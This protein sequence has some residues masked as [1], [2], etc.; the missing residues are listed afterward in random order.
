MSL[1]Q[2]M[3]V[4]AAAVVALWPG[5]KGAVEAGLTAARRV[6]S[7]STPPVGDGGPSFQLAIANLALVRHRLSET[8]LLDDQSKKAID[9]L[10]L[11]LV[12]GSD[13]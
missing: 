8:E 2:M 11:A 9:T 12:A 6:I 5:L 3:L 13:Q 7:K 10:T 1:E 4:G